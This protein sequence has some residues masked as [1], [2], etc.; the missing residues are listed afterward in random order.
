MTRWLEGTFLE[1]DVTSEGEGTRLDCSAQRV[2]WGVGVHAHIG[3]A[4]TKRSLHL[5]SH[6]GAE[7]TTT[8]VRLLDVALSVRSAETRRERTDA[9]TALNEAVAVLPLEV[10]DR[11]QC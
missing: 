6:R 7:I 10:Q 3:Q 4:G 2:R 9:E 5:R 1:V 8:S 11:T